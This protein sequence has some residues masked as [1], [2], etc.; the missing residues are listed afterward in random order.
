M[1]NENKTK[2]PPRG[3][4]LQTGYFRVAAWD[5]R[6]EGG[7]IKVTATFTLTTADRIQAMKDNVRDDREEGRVQ[8]TK[9]SA[10]DADRPVDRKDQRREAP[11]DDKRSTGR[12]DRRDSGP[13]Y[14]R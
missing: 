11:R 6:D 7:D 1:S 8:E 5:N 4:D 2:Q 10:R 13:R 3:P 14:E 9:D 12:E